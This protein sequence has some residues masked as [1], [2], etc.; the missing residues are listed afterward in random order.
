M[1]P[2]RNS[3]DGIFPF[4]GKQQKGVLG[5]LV[6]LL[7][8]SYASTVAHEEW[9][10]NQ[11]V[12]ECVKRGQVQRFQEQYHSPSEFHFNYLQ[13]HLER[14][15]AYMAGEILPQEAYATPLPELKET[16]EQGRKDRQE[17]TDLCGRD[18]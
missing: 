15:S 2:A 1:D 18:Q 9:L 7:G 4:S 11:A 6:V 16:A 14:L 10:R 8:F 5:A 17:L 13:Q 12:Q 3:D